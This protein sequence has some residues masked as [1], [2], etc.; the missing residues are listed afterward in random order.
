VSRA[1][2]HLTRGILV[3]EILVSGRAV[4]KSLSARIRELR[5]AK[6]WTRTDLAAAA[7]VSKQYVSAL[8]LGR[9]HNPTSD[10]L[11]RLAR[12]LDT[13]AAGF[14]SEEI[15]RVETNVAGRVEDVRDPRYPQLPVYRWGTCGDPRDENSA[16]DPDHLEYPPVGRESL[17]GGRG[18]GV[19]VRGDSMV[20]QGINDGDTVWIN[21]MATTRSGRPVLANVV[22][23]DGENGMVV[24]LLVNEHGADRLVSHGPRGVEPF[25]YRE[26]TIIGRVVWVSPAGFP[27]GDRS[28]FNYA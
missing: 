12:A 14:L 26:Y 21:P 19:M 25:L 17:I 3:T 20:G 6:G 11:S 24:K 15:V 1:G 7:G 18:F 2:P 5:E 8:E 22:G 27:P 10:V 16:P 4:A 28:S 13:P 9:T 23:D